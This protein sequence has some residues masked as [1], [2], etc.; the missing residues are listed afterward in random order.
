MAVRPSRFVIASFMLF[1]LLLSTSASASVYATT[2]SHDVMQASHSSPTTELIGALGTNDYTAHD[3]S[4]ADPV[5]YTNAYVTSETGFKSE[6]G[7]WE[8][9]PYSDR[10]SVQLNTNKFSTSYDG[11]A[12][13][14]EVQ[15][16]FEEQGCPLSLP[17][18]YG[19]D[20]FIEYWLIPSTGSVCPSGWT[21]S[22]VGAQTYC[23]KNGP[24]TSGLPYESPANLNDYQWNAVSDGLPNL[25]FE[26]C[27]ISAGKCWTTQASP[28][29]LGLGSSGH[30]TE[31]EA[32]VFGDAAG[33]G[34][35]FNSGLTLTWKVNLGNYG[36]S[37]V[38]YIKQSFTEETNN[39]NVEG[40]PTFSGT[41]M[42]FSEGD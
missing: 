19:A 12:G 16:I 2:I 30:W 25:T 29:Y 18:C 34:A 38:S 11:I 20:L 24:T 8:G 39:L 9:I 21:S 32:N 42:T 23:D 41:T 35:T 15:F 1:T 5:L 22:L 6:S 31:T 4:S 33:T 14:G 7:S 36:S 28:D 10:Y 3:T 40:S 37:D 17:T 26:F 13:Q 27:N